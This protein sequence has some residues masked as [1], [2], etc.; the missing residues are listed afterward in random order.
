MLPT[1]LLERLKTGDHPSYKRKVNLKA[2]LNAAKC[3]GYA[4]KGLRGFGNDVNIR[5]KTIDRLD[6]EHPGWRGYPVPE[7]EGKCHAH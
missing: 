2:L 4:P 1:E 5:E 7:T 6:V 3:Y